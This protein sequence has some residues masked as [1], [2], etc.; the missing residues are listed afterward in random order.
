M[1]NTKKSTP[2]KSGTYTRAEINAA[3]ARSARWWCYVGAAPRN[4]GRRQTARERH[5]V[6]T[7]GIQRGRIIDREEAW[8]RAEYEAQA[9]EWAYYDEMEGRR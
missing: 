3:K 6:R 7:R 4:H 5:A 9:A 1:T 2:L 8:A